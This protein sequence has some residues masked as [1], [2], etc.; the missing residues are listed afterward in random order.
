MMLSLV[1]MM[2]ML[3]LTVLFPGRSCFMP[4]WLLMGFVTVLRVL[5][6]SAL[7]GGLL[8]AITVIGVFFVLAVLA[9]LLRTMSLV[10]G[11]LMFVLVVFFVVSFFMSRRLGV[12]MLIC[13]GF[14][15]SLFAVLL[16][17]VLVFDVH[18]HVVAS[19]TFERE[20]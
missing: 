20:L 6:V 15:M 5:L 13:G 11:L 2:L 18:R 7:L 17:A 19:L 14:A 12:A 9:C 8:M 4:C 1:A 16:L 3:F 10:G